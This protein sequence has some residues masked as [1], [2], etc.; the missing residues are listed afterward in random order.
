MRDCELFSEPYPCT[1]NEG[2]CVK[3]GGPPVNTT[4]TTAKAEGESRRKAKAEGEAEVLRKFS[5]FLACTL[6]DKFVWLSS[7]VSTM[8]NE[9]RQY[10]YSQ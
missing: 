3:P 2:E 1:L 10:H 7:V 8:D 4:S 9:D 5:Y 6:S